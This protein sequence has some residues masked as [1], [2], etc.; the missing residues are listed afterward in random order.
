MASIIEGYEYDIFISYRQKDNKHDGWVTEFVEN[1]KGELESTFKEDISVYF[2]F[3]PHNGLLETHDVEA[4]LKDKL[5]CLLFI[6][7]ISQTYCDSKSFAW[8]NEFCAFNKLAKEDQFGRDVKLAGGNV[9]SRILPVRIHDL[10]SEDKTL[11]EN[12]LGGVLRSIEFI[13][14]EAGVNRPLKPNDDTK[15]NLNKTSYINQI[16]KVANTIKEIITALQKPGQDGFVVSKKSFNSKPELSKYM[17]SRTILISAFALAL[18][19]LGYFFVAT[20]FKPA[21]PFEKSIAVLPFRNDSQDAQNQPF[22][23]GTMEAILDNLCKVSDL[24]VISRTSVEQ[25]RNTTKPIREI[26]RKLNVNYILEGSGQKYGNNIRLTVQLID[27][28]N[29][30]H[31]WS[32][33]YEGITDNIFK[34]Q[35]QISEAI[36]LNLKAIISPEER[37]LIEREPTKS[38][39]AY[40]LYTQARSEHMKFWSDNTNITGLNKAMILYRKVLKYDYTYAQ[41]YSGLA[42]G[43]INK[44][45]VQTN[46]NANFLD[47][48][49]IYA[50]KAISYNDHLDEA[51]YDRAFFYNLTGDYDKALKDF[52]KAIEINPN[53][54]SAYWARGS[55]Y[56]VKYWNTYNAIEDQIKSAQLEH[57]PDRPERMRSLGANF[58]NLGFTEIARYYYEAA[59]K[60]DNDSTSYLNDLAGLEEY[61]Q[62]DSGAV[63]LY[64]K[65]LERDPSNL[66]ALQRNLFCYEQLGR[67]K[68]A[69]RTANIIIRIYN[70]TGLSPQNNWEYIGYAFLKTGHI[71]EAKNY[72]DMQI[73]KCE[74]ILALDP[75]TD[76]AINALI[77]VYS[78]LGDNSKALQWLNTLYERIKERNAKGKNIASLAFQKMLNYN[79]LMDNLRSDTTFQRIQRDLAVTYKISHEKAKVWLMEKGVLK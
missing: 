51:F 26:A 17:K 37:L 4:S 60:L 39:I 43:Y 77:R 40:N 6:P 25:F 8:Q 22:I 19:I 44:L 13:Y 71:K 29:D 42:H 28:V 10:D 53:Y 27:A 5:K 18:I 32:S 73:D 67:Y 62:N 65:V 11:L 24:I 54:S 63:E 52:N 46:Q 59:I 31:I 66:T 16:N 68:E 7:V 41:A 45:D 72:F 20:F 49:I 74:K 30:K 57:G 9:A 64:N 47:S 38:L 34:L 21:A 36:A 78:A 56:F 61:H 79:V 48:V 1:L 70:K 50:N 75:N 76:G 3:N 33:P 58:R 15:E 2:D 35:S 14:K 23:D 69:Y 55:L 12:E